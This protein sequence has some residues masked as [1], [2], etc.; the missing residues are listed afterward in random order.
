MPKAV[1]LLSSE[2]LSLVYPEPV[3]ARLRPL[4]ESL[5]VFSPP[6][7]WTTQPEALAEAEVIFSGWGAPRMDEAFLRRAPKL[8]ALFYA[9]GSVRY[10]LT[11]AFWARNI[12]VTT[13]QAIN[14]IPVAEFTAAALVMGLKRVW[15]Y[16]RL[17][18][19]TGSFPVQRPMAGAFGTTVGLVS[20]GIIARLVRARLRSLEV[21]VIV[22]DPFL[23]DAEAAAEGVTKVG[24]DE[25]FARSD[26]VSL[27]TPHLAETVG[28]VRGR[29]FEL[30]RE[31]GF[32]LNT[33]RGEVVAEDEMIAVLSRRPDL[34]AQL[35][36]TSPEPPRPDSP[37]YTLP[38]VLLTPHIAGSMG[39]ECQRMGMA[40]V[41]EFARYCAGE[42]LH[43]E[44]TA[45]RAARIA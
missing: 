13:A 29:H 2:A 34:Q 32:F 41:E 35:D 23:S 10:F 24:L 18:R 38:N 1:L 27:H 31:G 33:A 5:K 3:M 40:M 43:H 30:M 16:A 45:E 7:A 15:H 9:G 17:T 28:M 25:L 20:Y 6:E 44:I 11:E 22:Y 39:R 14:A 4:A 8:R 26:A 36:V 12:R 42:P 37:L 21:D 19:E